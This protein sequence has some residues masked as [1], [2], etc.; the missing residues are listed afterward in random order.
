MDRGGLLP[1]PC[2]WSAVRLHKS[3][4]LFSPHP[5]G[6]E[7]TEGKIGESGKENSGVAVSIRHFEQKSMSSPSANLHNKRLPSEAERGQRLPDVDA[8][9]QLKL[10]ERQRFFEEVF[11]HDVDVYLS[12]AHLSIRDY[13]RPPIGS[14]SSMEVNVDLLDQMELIDISDHETLDVFFSS[15]GEDGV[16]TSPLPV[17]GNNNNNEEVISNGLFRHVLESL[18][19]K[20]RMSSTSSNSSSDSQ[21]INAN[22]GDTPVVRSDDEETHTSTV[23]R[24]ATP[25][26]IEKM[27]SQ[28]P[29]SSS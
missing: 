8:A 29:S 3:T 18:E 22:G 11:Q 12:S 19:A 14:I 2:H 25:P 16:L 24:R 13:K 20:S 9:Q 26:E 6:S 10:R 7:S 1:P 21:I 15:G 28:T 17:Q 23:K 27:K 5:S 4:N